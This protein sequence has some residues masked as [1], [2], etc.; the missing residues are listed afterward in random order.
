MISC[1]AIGISLGAIAWKVGWKRWLKATPIL[2]IGW[3]VLFVYAARLP[4]D[5]GRFGWVGVGAI[6]FNVWELLPV[7]VALW[8]A[9]N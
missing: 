5:G 4:L 8:A 1:N 2:L 6:R 3:V 9:R 7:M